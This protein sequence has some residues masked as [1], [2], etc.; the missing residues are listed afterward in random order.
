MKAVGRVLPQLFSSLLCLLATE[1]R[2]QDSASLAIFVSDPSSAV[3]PG[4]RVSIVDNHR[5]T[6]TQV[7]TG[8]SGRADFD[9]LAPSDYTIEVEKPG[10]NKYRIENVNLAVRAREELRIQLQ[11]AA[12]SGTKVDVAEPAAGFARRLAAPPLLWGAFSLCGTSK[13]RCHCSG[14]KPA[15]AKACPQAAL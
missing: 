9:S 15:E 2:A 13:S 5:G 6:V 12:A 1:L 3:V 11:V 8:G 4:A 10:F 7:A 14:R